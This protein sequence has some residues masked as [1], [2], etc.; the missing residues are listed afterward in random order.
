VEHTCGQKRTLLR[1][2]ISRRDAFYVT[3]FAVGTL[4]YLWVIGIIWLAMRARRYLGYWPG[5]NH[6]D[7][8][9]VPFDSHREVLAQMFFALLWS[10][11]LMPILY[12]GNHWIFKVKLQ[13]RPLYIYSLG[14]MIIMLMT[15]VPRI[16]LVA[17]FLD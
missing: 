12:L 3:A 9:F 7:P 4:P 16:D 15:F 17:W 10:L 8:Q 5:P 13:R 14:W 2:T 1:K 6:P 11:V